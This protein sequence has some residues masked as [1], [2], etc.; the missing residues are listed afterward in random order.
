[1]AQ[2]NNRPSQWPKATVAILGTASISG[3]AY[4][5]KEPQIMWA[6]ILLTWVLSHF[7]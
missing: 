2:Q 3:A 4:F 1:M 6:M 7:D 5:L